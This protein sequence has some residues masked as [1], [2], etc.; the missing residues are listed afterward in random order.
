MAKFKVLLPLAIG[1]VALGA[2]VA[3]RIIP[4]G[5]SPANAAQAVAADFALPRSGDS[6][7]VRLSDFKGKVRIVNF[8]AT[9]CPP[10]RAEIPHFIEMYGELKGKGVEIIGISLDREGDKV[11]AP[12]VKENKMN[13]PVL[14]GN[15][16]VSSAYGGI[17][18]IP[19]TF[20]VDREG[21]I[22]KKYVGLPAQTEEGIKDAFMKDIKPLL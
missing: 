9:W 11:V 6:K 16:A 13:Y 4:T 5:E 10:C 7:T 14:I 12:F 21:R 2:I 1:L 20:I 17:R 19:T 18:G 3:P 8:W 22:V 15:D